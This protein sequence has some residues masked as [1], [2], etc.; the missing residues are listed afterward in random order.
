MVSVEEQKRAVEQLL[1]EKVHQQIKRMRPPARPKKYKSSVRKVADYVV[2][3]FETTG[4][5]SGADKII[6]IGAVKYIGHE[7][8][9]CFETLVNPRRHISPTIT[10]LTGITNEQVADAPAIEEVIGDLIGFI[11][12]FPI[13]AHNA[14]F[15]MSFLYAL[16]AIEGI[17]IPEYTVIDTVRLARKVITETTNHKLGTLAHY[18]R[19]EHRAHDAIG[20]CLATA[21]IY[22]YCLGVRK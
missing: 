20:D 16:D 3:D 22:Q 11:G 17:T 2:L 14:A 10:R 15:D 5:R 6:Q 18:L 13:I 12:D 9:G 4:F 19:L 1:E 7:Q 8:Q 21:A